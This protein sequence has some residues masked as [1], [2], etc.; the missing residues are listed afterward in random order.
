MNT[1][2]LQAQVN[3]RFTACFGRTPLKQRLDDIFGEAIELSRY[4]DMK[5][6]KEEAGDLLSS[7][8]QLAT[9]CEWDPEE[10]VANT[11]AK[12][13]AR[14]LQYL[15]LGRKTKVVIFGGAFDPITLGHVRTAQAV[16]NGA[17]EFDE[18]WLT[19]VYGHMNGKN[20]SPPEQRL[21]MCELAAKCD[22]RIKVFDYEVENKLAGD[23][24]QFAKRLLDEPF[25]K[26]QYDFSLCIGQDNA[27]SFDT[28]VRSDILRDMIR[29]VVVP[30]PG[31]P[32]DPTAQW[33]LKPPHI[34]LAPDKTQ[35]E[36][37]STEVRQAIR[38]LPNTDP[39]HIKE[40][41]D[42][43]DPAVLNYIRENNLYGR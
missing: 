9:E 13:E 27:N 22:G 34:Y 30:R 26:D 19:P 2:E 23:T 14:K 3:E 21:A 17:H 16:L 41:Q 32:F 6:L 40:L 35:L 42:V 29:F 5:N 12:I 15:T 4:T 18:A 28:W 33:Y 20:M 11:L 25:A 36:I 37:S 8:L 1:R 43:M 10:L 39:V 31:V 38:S 24:Y 7:L